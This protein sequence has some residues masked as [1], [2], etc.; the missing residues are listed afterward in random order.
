[1]KTGD[2]NLL[3]HFD[4]LQ[5]EV[6]LP[7]NFFDAGDAVQTSTQNLHRHTY[8]EFFFCIDP[9]VITTS[10]GEHVFENSVVI[11]PPRL[12]HYTMRKN[13][14]NFMV[15]FSAPHGSDSKRY[16]LLNKNL[17]KTEIPILP[18]TEKT[19]LY[20]R[21]LRLALLEKFKDRQ[22]KLKSLLTLIMLDVINSYAEEQSAKES[23]SSAKANYFLTVESI[24][25]SK[26]TTVTTLKQLAKLLHLSEKQTSR[27][28]HKAYGQSFS[29]IINDKRLEV[30]K[31]LLVSTEMSVS[32]V[33]S[34]LNFKSESYFFALFKK[35]YG[36]TPHVYCKRKKDGD[37]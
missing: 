29:D 9:L 12:Q 32:Q 28:I 15:R 31:S 16:N 10:S 37:L 1:M 4:D 18:L 3:L 30:A 7:Q 14:Y 5:A 8:Y 25:A 22:L 36:T 11:I 24:I 19:L 21:D 34:F 2:I 6:F 20:I 23:A 13:V 17:A 27:F 35:K 33:I 26:Y